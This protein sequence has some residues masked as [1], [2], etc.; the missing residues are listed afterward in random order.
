MTPSDLVE[1]LAQHTTLGSAPREELAWLATHGTV[2]HLGE[3]EVLTRKDTTVQ[4]MYVVLS[5]HIA[6]FVERGASRD[7][8]M[9][10]RA[11]DVTG[12]LPYSRLASPPGNTVAQEPTTILAVDRTR[13]R[14]MTRECHEV[15]TIL[16]HSMV[17][18]ARRFTSSDLR[19]EK[20]ASLGK[21]AAGLAHELNN[22]AAA[23]ERSAALLDDRLE[24]AESATRILG[25]SS[26][27]DEQLA[28]IDT[29]RNSCLMSSAK[30]ILSP[31]QRAQREDDIADWLGVHGLDDR[32]ASL[33]AETAVTI[34]ALDRIAE[35][36][37]G[38]ALGAVLRWAAAGCSV[39][40]LA[41]EIQD[42]AMRITGLV[43]AVK[44]FTHMDQAPAAEPLD[45]AMNLGNTVTVLKSKARR[46]SIAVTI[47][48]EPEL[49]HVVGFVGELNQ[50]WA[51]LIDN[52][53]DAVAENGRVDVTAR[54][55]RGHVVVRIVDNGPGIPPEVLSRM[56]EPFFT[57]KPVG[58][59]TG[60]GLDIVRRL[61][62]HNNADID[63][64]STP[65]HTEFRVSLPIAAAAQAGRPS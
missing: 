65:G 5:G 45:L 20:M 42:A 58:Q 23:I 60:L 26:L 7:K 59:G 52:A 51:N 43:Q 47:V 16:V 13:L 19:N 27:T 22:P 2:R 17:D 8:V 4:G 9:E 25:A 24:E 30:G 29:V 48:V 18:R 39:R 1:Q 37:S 34:D 63:V 21:L 12:M 10:W 57:T 40:E 38:P 55:E 44:G 14:D 11:G 46:K 28:A 49:P 41:S 15:T 6:I 3:G 54:H 33:L 53:L 31:L 64:E 36:V 61:L 56:F 50:I 32:L 35:A 62:S